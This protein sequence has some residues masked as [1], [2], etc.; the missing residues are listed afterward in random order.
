MNLR[1]VFQQATLNFIE[2]QS[3]DY[4]AGAGGFHCEHDLG[5]TADG[6]TLGYHLEQAHLEAPFLPNEVLQLVIHLVYHH[7]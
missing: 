6:I 4:I 5:V 1:S 7:D 3:L 2:L